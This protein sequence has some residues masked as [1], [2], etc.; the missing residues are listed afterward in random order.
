M[1]DS[2]LFDHSVNLRSTR[3]A[4][5]HRNIFAGMCFGTQRHQR[6]L[7]KERVGGVDLG[8]VRTHRE[9]VVEAAGEM[10]KAFRARRLHVRCGQRPRSIGITQGGVRAAIPIM[11]VRAIRQTHFPEN[12]VPAHRIARDRQRVTMVRCD[13]D[14]GIRLI[15]QPLRH[16]HGFGQGNGVGKRPIRVARVMAVIDPTGFHHQEEP[17]AS[18]SKQADCRLRH[19]RK[20]RLPALVA[21]SIRL[22][23]H[24]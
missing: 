23:F 21:R 5:I 3:T 14:Q 2:V 24:V 20:G 15:R 19:L 17:L 7:Q 1:V 4:R 6:L 22:I 10:W 16:R 18:F 12:G 11:S 8:E 13:D 9:R